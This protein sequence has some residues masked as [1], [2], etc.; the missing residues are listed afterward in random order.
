[1]S[2]L[3]APALARL[4]ASRPHVRAV[5]F[6]MAMMA[7]FSVLETT[8]KYLSRTYPVP[9]VVW[10]RYFVHTALIL[11]ILAPRLG[12]AL[13]R[14]RQPAGQLV[15][16]TLLMGS[17]LFNFSALSFLPMAEVKAI[18]FVSPLLVT[19]FAVW[20]LSERV[21]RAGSRSPPGFSG[22][23]SSSARAA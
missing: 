18:S 11:A 3:I 2:P 16:A 19:V 10:W 22:C 14:T 21:N 17:T 1:M 9:M 4:R 13:V 20:L 6:M 12:L 8:A 5:L 15:R 7:C 23:C